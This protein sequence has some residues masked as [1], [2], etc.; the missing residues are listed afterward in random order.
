M[1]PHKTIAA[2]RVADPGPRSV[3]DWLG[4]LGCAAFGG[5]ALAVHASTY[6]PFFADDSFISLQY[7]RRLLDGKGLTFADGEWVEGYSNLLW[8]LLV[9]G[10]GALGIE[11]VDAA[12]VLGL[13]CMVLA[14]GVVSVRFWA[15]GGVASVGIAAFLASS[16]AMAIW[17]VGGLEQSLVALLLSVAFA[18]A[19]PLLQ[20]R[21]TRSQVA[22]PA[23]A[24]AALCLTRPDGPLFTVALV[25]GLVLAR[26]DVDGVRGAALVAVLPVLATVGQLAFRLSYYGDWVPNTAHVKLGL[27]VEAGL[28]WWG[29]GLWHHGALVAAAALCGAA[30]PDERAR[31]RLLLVLPAVVLWSVYVVSVGGDIFPGRRHFVPLVVLLAFGVGEGLLWLSRV[32]RSAG[33]WVMGVLVCGHGLIQH[34][35]GENRRAHR[36]RWE[37][38]CAVTGTLLAEAFGEAEPLL[39]AGAAGCMPYFS[40]LNTLDLWGLNDRYLATH[41]L[42]NRK[43]RLGH[44]MGDL[45][46]VLDREPD[47]LQFGGVKGDR[48]LKTAMGK[49]L[50]SDPRFRAAYR[51][52]PF[53]G[54]DP[55]RFR[56]HLWVR[57]AGPIGV[58]R[59]E[60]R[61]EIPG[62]LMAKNRNSVARLDDSGR[63]GVDVSKGQPVQFE[64]I[65]VYR[66][67]DWNVRVE[68]SGGP[69]T[70]Q[71]SSRGLVVVRASGPPAHVRTV[72]LS[73]R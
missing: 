63:L 57:W 44:R 72:V 8:V 39:A 12:R 13:L 43:H 31:R 21:P 41:P 47:L 9:A 23:L 42:S 53:E 25:V 30:W 40:G 50:A 20:G 54:R 34:V 67:E 55:H 1:T 24:L 35:D 29:S 15:S 58:R 52:V 61:V 60:G 33:W 10:M 64:D 18:S 56:A 19:W 69:V 5:V 3:A 37:W 26:R 65:G 22:L 7:A 11:L 70:A 46:Y 68:A 32:H 48:Q 38:D 27:G 2:T 66:P 6:L 17:A 73:R 51:V 59:E 14:L 49:Q 71:V 16:G 4:A 45:R 36:E 28:G 62:F